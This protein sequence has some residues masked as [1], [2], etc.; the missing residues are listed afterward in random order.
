ML[1]ARQAA[2]SRA[3]ATHVSNV[4]VALLLSASESATAPACCEEWRVR[5]A[6][7]ETG[8]PAQS[9]ARATYLSDVIKAQCICELVTIPP[10]FELLK[11]NSFGVH[12]CAASQAASNVRL[13]KTGAASAVSRSVSLF[14]SSCL[15]LSLRA[16]VFSTLRPGRDAHTPIAH[17]ACLACLL[18]PRA[19]PR[20]PPARPCR[21]QQQPSRQ[22]R[23]SRQ[24]QQQ[25]T[26]RSR[27]SLRTCGAGA[28][29]SSTGSSGAA[30][31]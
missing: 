25:P 26:L 20:P 6:R 29:N 31:C 9:K 7:N 21:Q 11:H 27:S 16:S 12:L 18:A 5:D 28:G 14:P 17:L 10:A 19:C 15:R 1:V 2:Q 8:P 13:L 3:R 30:C 23:P 4:S 24:Q 22:Q